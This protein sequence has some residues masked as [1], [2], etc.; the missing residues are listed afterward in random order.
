MQEIHTNVLFYLIMGFLT[1]LS[2][3]TTLAC[4]IS[5]SCVLWGRGGGQQH[6]LVEIYMLMARL[7]SS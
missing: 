1:M 4:S 6:I 3:P 2:T 7:V 5:L